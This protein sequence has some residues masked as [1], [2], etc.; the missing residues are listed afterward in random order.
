MPYDRFLKEKHFYNRVITF[1]VISSLSDKYSTKMNAVYVD[2][3]QKETFISIGYVCT[4]L[5]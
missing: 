4:A 2:I 3:Y 5:K 1:M